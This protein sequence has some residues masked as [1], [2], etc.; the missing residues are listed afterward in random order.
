MTIGFGARISG[1]VELR[2]W[3]FE[4]GAAVYAVM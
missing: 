3:T 2:T 4:N 1:H